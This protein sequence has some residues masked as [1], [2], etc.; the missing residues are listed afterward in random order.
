MP[1]IRP[2]YA[3]A[4]PTC[5]LRE[6]PRG[7]PHF[8]HSARLPVLPNRVLLFREDFLD[9]PSCPSSERFDPPRAIPLPK[10]LNR[11]RAIPLIAKE[12]NSNLPD[13]HRET[14]SIFF[15]LRRFHHLSAISFPIDRT[16]SSLSRDVFQLF[17]TISLS[18]ELNFP[19]A[20]SFPRQLSLIRAVPPPS[21][22]LS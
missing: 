19:R 10:K 16:F 12:I 22:Y 18:G 14:D 8:S 20:A 4:A 15:I 7:I 11:P 17:R 13:G 9:L 6:Q 21:I 2:G 5:L 1:Y 3:E